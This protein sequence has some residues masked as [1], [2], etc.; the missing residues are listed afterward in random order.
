MFDGTSVCENIHSQSR[1]MIML[2]PEPNFW[3]HA[4][5]E[6]AR[7]PRPVDGSLHDLAL[8]RHILR[9]YELF[10]LTHGSFASILTALGQQ[11][12]EL[13]IERFFTVWAW[14]WD[15]E[16]DVNFVTH[17]GPFTTSPIQTTR[18]YPGHIYLQ[19]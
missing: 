8:R 14:K 5:L 4:C 10:K 7:I 9:G 13:Q 19:P 3:I 17:L 11:A 12:L 18:P 15:P 6:L 2:S 16:E 1:R